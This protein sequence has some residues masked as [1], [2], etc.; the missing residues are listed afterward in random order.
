MG[1]ICGGGA[2]K[3]HVAVDCRPSSPGERLFQELVFDSWFLL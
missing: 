1:N 2:G 3:A